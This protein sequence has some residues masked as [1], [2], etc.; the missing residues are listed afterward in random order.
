MMLQ[1]KHPLCDAPPVSNISPRVLL[2]DSDPEEGRLIAHAVGGDRVEVEVDADVALR[3]IGA[4][5]TYDLIL[6]VPQEHRPSGRQLYEAISAAYQRKASPRDLPLTVLIMGDTE[7]AS[8]YSAA[9]IGVLSKP[10][11][12]A[13]VHNLLELIAAEATEPRADMHPRGVLALPQQRASE[14]EPRQ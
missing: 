12:E 10:I 5:T 13:S 2:I 8:A 14:R 4:G 1:S 7:E 9:G 3:N 11:T 6:Y